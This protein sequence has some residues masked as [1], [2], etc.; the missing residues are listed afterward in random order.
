MK[1]SE[2]LIGALAAAG[3]PAVANEPAPGDTALDRF[4][5]IPTPE[6]RFN[7]VSTIHG[8]GY[9]ARVLSMTSQRW[10]TAREVDRPEWTHWLTITEPEHRRTNIALLVISGGSNTD[11]APARASSIVAEVARRTGAVVAELQVVPNQPLSFAGYPKPLGEDD[12]VAYSWDKY[13]HTADE[14]WPLHLPMAKAAVRAMDTVTALLPSVSRFVVGGASK[15][16]WAAWLTA[17]AD[18]RVVAVVPVVIDTLNVERSALHAY[19]SYGTWP[20]ALKSYEQYGIMKWFGTPQLDALLKIEDPYNYRERLTMPKLI[21]N[22]AGDQFFTPDSSQFY[23]E[24]LP[25]KKYLRYIPNTD[26]SLSGA[27]TSAAQT[28]R[29]F[30]DGL[31]ANA[32]G[33][34]YD[35][36]VRDGTLSVTTAAK[37]L[38]AKLWHAV[39]PHARDFRLQSIGHAFHST[40]VRGHANRTYSAQLEPPKRGFAA[41][42][43][44]LTY[45][46]LADDLFTV[47]T[48]VAIVPDV[49]PFALPPRA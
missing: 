46:T 49:L 25:G 13:L 3:T 37:P 27:A 31:I 17:A 12:L 23:F 35:W 42:F 47:T 8:Y 11:H 29:A 45:E 2:F 19:R 44:E 14:T 36:D 24:G 18:K 20:D 39:N 26:H 5:A 9:R 30:I 6:Y 22:A 16:G 1:R 40:E 33:P 21:V 15:R 41:Y 38:E 10:R 32:Q 4:I 43:M 48:D 28:G 7:V 34:S